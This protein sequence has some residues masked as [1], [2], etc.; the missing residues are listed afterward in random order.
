MGSLGAP[1]EGAAI[2]HWSPASG[3][4]VV[5]GIGL[6]LAVLALA[7]MQGRRLPA[8]VR[9]ASTIGEP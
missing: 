6:V 2:D 1:I 5:G 9:A 8:S 3:F 7:P 4:V